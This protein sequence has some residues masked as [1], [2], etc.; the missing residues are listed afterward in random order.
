MVYGL[1]GVHNI[2][3]I[4]T[5]NKQ[6]QRDPPLHKFFVNVKLD[7][8]VEAETPRDAM[9][10]VYAYLRG[11]NYLSAKIDNMMIEEEDQEY[12]YKQVDSM[13]YSG[14]GEW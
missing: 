11:T 4:M 12:K 9:E 13:D 10:Q 8:I 2:T 14:L 7:Y 1:Y 3:V 5:K 6:Q